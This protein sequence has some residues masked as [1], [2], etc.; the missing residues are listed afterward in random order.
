VQSSILQTKETTILA[1]RNLTITGD[2]EQVYKAYDLV[3][4][5]AEE[6]LQEYQRQQPPVREDRSGG[7][8]RARSRSPPPRGG[9]SSGYGWD[10][11]PAKQ[12]RGDGGRRAS[13]F[14]LQGFL[15]S[16]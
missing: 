15:N 9:S 5:R 6:V 2:V 1:I 13:D 4:D 3:N 11:G 10:R 14:A 16:Y 12:Q 7:R 8:Y